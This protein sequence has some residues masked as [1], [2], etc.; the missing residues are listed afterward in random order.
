MKKHDIEQI[1]NFHINRLNN[2]QSTIT[3]LS[4]IGYTLLSI[5]LI[6][7][8]ILLPLIFSL[9][10]INYARITIAGIMVLTTI[11]MFYCFAVNLN[12]ERV[13]VN[14]YNNLLEINLEELC[15]KEN[16]WK[17]IA[18]INYIQSKKQ[19]KEKANG[20]FK[21]RIK[22]YKSWVSLLWINILAIDI[23]ALIITILIR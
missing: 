22:K 4:N 1:S 9:N 12:N 19:L 18:S 8:G 7:S 14:I 6:I 21:F 3:R 15:N 13:F 5:N 16:P 20:S 11:V 2:I 10:M 23:V 17:E